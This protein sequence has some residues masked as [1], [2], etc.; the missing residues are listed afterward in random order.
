MFFDNKNK[1]GE[2]VLSKQYSHKLYISSNLAYISGLCALYNGYF[3][4]YWI[5]LYAGA[6]SNLYW[7]DP[8]YGGRRNLDIWMCLL[9]VGT[10]FSM[11]YY[12]QYRCH[13][14]YYPY[15]LFYLGIG[16][17]TQALIFGRYFNSEST[18][19]MFH[20]FFHLFINGSAISLYTC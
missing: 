5:W 1:N 20:L 12:D 9:N 8:R 3:L 18:S 6:A 15:F 11:I 16:S 13:S 17:Y 7:N 2:L 19:S 14:Y 10:H 4:N